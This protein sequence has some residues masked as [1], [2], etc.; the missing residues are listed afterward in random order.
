[1]SINMPAVEVNAAANPPVN[2]Q[3]N[4]QANPASAHEDKPEN[5]KSALL[6]PRC[7]SPAGL[8]DQYCAICGAPLVLMRLHDENIVVGAETTSVQMVVENKGVA[9]GYFAL[10]SADVRNLPPWLSVPQGINDRS[11][12]VPAG[13]SRELAFVV[14]PERLPQS[15]DPHGVGR[16]EIPFVTAVMVR[17]VEST[18]SFARQMLKAE[19]GVVGSAAVS[20]K[21]WLYRFIPRERVTGGRLVPVSVSVKNCGG[22]PI[23]LVNVAANSTNPART[24]ESWVQLTTPQILRCPPISQPITI[25]PDAEYTY[26]FAIS[27]QDNALSENSVGVFAASITFSFKDHTPSDVTTRIDGVIGAGPTV[28]L[29]SAPPVIRTGGRLARSSFTLE[30]AGS[31]P[32]QVG[33]IDVIPQNPDG[34]ILGQN[35]AGVRWLM[36]PQ[37]KQGFILEAGEQKEIHF[38]IDPERFQGAEG[39]SLWQRCLIRFYHDGWQESDKRFLDVPLVVEM[40]RTKF[41]D[42]VVLGI[43]FGTSNSS[44]SL[45]DGQNSR[46]MPI[47]LDA[48]VNAEAI[49]SLMFYRGER[50]GMG[51]RERFLYGHA[52]ANSAETQSAHLVRS[53]KTAVARD[54]RSRWHFFENNENLVENS[55]TSNNPTETASN[56]PIVAGPRQRTY[57]AGELLAIFVAELKERIERGLASLP[58]VWLE[59]LDIS[60]AVPRVRRA[61]FTHPVGASDEMLNALYTA[62]KAVRLDHGVNAFADFKERS[63]LDEALASVL[64]YIYTLANSGLLQPQSVEPEHDVERILCF[65]AGGGTTDLA[66]VEV[67]GLQAFLQS[68]SAITVTLCSSNG[69]SSLGGEDFDQCVAGYLLTLLRNRPESSALDIEMVQRALEYPSYEG[70]RRSMS[71]SDHILQQSV[72]DEKE[73][74]IRA[75]FARGYD[76][77][78]HAEQLKRALT[79]GGAAM[80]SIAID[81]WPLKAAGMRRSNGN[82]DLTVERAVVPQLYGPLL[83]RAASLLDPLVR[84]AGW[85]WDQ[86]TTLL[87]T[88]QT[89]LI[90][91][92]RDT[93]KEETQKRRSPSAIPLNIVEPGA[94]AGFDPKR[95]V[96]LGAAIWGDSLLGGGG[97][98]Q[99]RSRS[100]TQLTATLEMRRGPLFVPV[101]GLEAGSNLPARGRMQFAVPTS[102][103]ELYQARQLVWEFLLPSPCR[104][105]EII[106]NSTHEVRAQYKSADGTSAGEVVGQKPRSV[107]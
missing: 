44:A 49:P 23:S 73:A 100:Q 82:L 87:F 91:E 34:V 7:Q 36:F 52:A 80:A 94:L 86:V 61:I 31:I 102:K 71:E 27:L 13:G 77:L 21:G 18:R 45:F 85:Q 56:K 103:I 11:I 8:T 96:A 83:T 55:A 12:E 4:P 33:Q 6:C 95:C 64:A 37:G 20:P 76:L 54:V 92:L 70:F 41:I 22:Q 90:P 51:A 2:P 28:S 1:M 58:A 10:R 63:C 5:T 78:R 59:S 15:G 93:V 16:A 38:A 101:A 74:R 89:S 98:L 42:N 26:L 29:L 24:H 47:Y 65:D 60:E 30:N 32:V 35:D 69:D 75:A 48:P 79:K 72:I 17:S 46:S 57:E 105:V 104:E 53:L 14:Y 84:D 19:I 40:G 81:E 97:W 106:V 9:S 3:A 68:G 43:D 66:A 88:G 62:A 50:M 39:E 25:A 107:R 67:R 99:V